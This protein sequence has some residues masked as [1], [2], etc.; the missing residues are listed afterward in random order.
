MK[1]LFAEPRC[2]SL[3]DAQNNFGET[4]LHLCAGSG[5]KSAA[6]AALLLLENGASLALVDK[7]Y[8]GPLNVSHD[9]AE[10]SL[11]QVLK[12]HIEKPGNEEIKKATEEITANY[13]SNQKQYEE[14]QQ[15]SKDKQKSAILGALGLGGA[16]KGNGGGGGLLAA[17]GGVSL[18]KTV[19]KEK[20]M[21]MKSEGVAG[22]GGA[23]TYNVTSKR[24]LSKLCEFPGD[25]DEITKWVEDDKIDLNGTDAFGLLAIHKFAS[26]NKTVFL[27]LL[28]PKLSPADMNKQCPEGKTAL[29][30]AVE[31]AAVGAVKLLVR[32]GVDRSIVDGK[33][34]TVHTILDSVEQSNVI[35]RLKEALQTS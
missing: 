16:N 13:K 11:V 23:S 24:P 15:Q 35:K 29:H 18:K 10:N 21:F 26:W 7:W 14:E 19:M 6:K 9:N 3:L 5:D 2:R 28:L 33:G 8:R 27:E 4:A 1:L 25:L 22:K 32:H 31:M 34:R 17:L 20:T 30:W 12:H